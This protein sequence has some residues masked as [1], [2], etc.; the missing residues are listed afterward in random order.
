MC[1]RL[2][3]KDNGA[4]YDDGQWGKYKLHQF[5]FFVAVPQMTTGG[6]LAAKA[7]YIQLS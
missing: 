6:K 5:S 2:K 1:V 4:F 7:D 3:I